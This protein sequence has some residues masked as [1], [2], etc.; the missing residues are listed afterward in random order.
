M[1]KKELARRLARA[2]QLTP[3]DAADS[4]DVL[5]RDIRRRTRSGR[6]VKIPGLGTFRPGAE[7]SFDDG[8]PRKD[9]TTR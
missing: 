5:V 9:A 3:A 1:K 4:V 2:L 7:V 8:A 6:S